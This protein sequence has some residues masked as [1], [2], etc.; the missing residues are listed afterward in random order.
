MRNLRINFT[1]ARGQVYTEFLFVSVTFSMFSHLC[2][3]ARPVVLL[4]TGRASRYGLCGSP[5][6]PQIF[7]EPDPARA[8]RNRLHPRRL[9]HA[10]VHL[11]FSLLFFF[12]MR[13]AFRSAERRAGYYEQ[14]LQNAPSPSL[15][16]VRD[17]G[18]RLDGPKIGR[19]RS[20]NPHI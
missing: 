16:S 19:S 18:A 11:F 15:H 10:R 7:M 8:K 12:F 6:T 20:A 5:A 2:L 17:D 3:V 13:R 1:S 9:C 4:G 14:G